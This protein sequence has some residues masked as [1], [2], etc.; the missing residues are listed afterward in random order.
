[1]SFSRTTTD[2]A[3]ATLAQAHHLL[4]DLDGTLIREQEPI[5]G[6]AELLTRFHDRFAIV[7]NN[8]TH[9][10]AGL[11]RRLRR[12]G[13]R[14]PPERIVLA[15]EWAVQEL[16][17]CAPG[18]RTLVVASPAIQHLARALGCALVQVGAEFVLLALD[19]RFSHA[20]LTQVA[21]E[22]RR[23][24]KLIVTNTDAT[25]PGAGGR[26]VPET[27]ALLAAVVAAG[28]AAPWRVIGKPEP[29]LFD[30]G[31]RRLGARAEH[32]LVIGDNALT[33]GAGAMRLGLPCLLVGTG[34]GAVAADVGG[35]LAWTQPLPQY[36]LSDS[37]SK[38]R[39]SVPTALS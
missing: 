13:L 20:R 17:R 35:L 25:H 37:T 5:E 8:S 31:M 4:I 23:G 15:G 38:V 18:A 14:V 10:S 16:A 1:M 19:M 2:F 22:V 32:T 21:N 36:R 34:S 29:M 28:G 26:V 11:S 12:L 39:R 9:T 33:D 30:E 24:A 27:G 3:S 6:A 7:S